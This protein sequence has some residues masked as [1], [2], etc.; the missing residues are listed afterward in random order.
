ME[1]PEGPS[2]ARDEDRKGNEEIIKHDKNY[3]IEN[4][5]NTDKI[6]EKI[7]NNFNDIKHKYGKVLK[8]A[9]HQD[10][11]HSLERH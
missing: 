1:P 10:L 6:D 3:A 2:E 4:E 11:P 8:K 7:N 5:L 9:E